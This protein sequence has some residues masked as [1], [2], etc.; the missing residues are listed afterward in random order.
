[1]RLIHAMCALLVALA[2]MGAAPAVAAA[3]AVSLKATDQ[4]FRR[5]VNVLGY[6]PYWTNTSER[7]FQW[8]HFA[9]IRKAGFDFVRVNLQA[10]SHMDDQNRLDSVWLAKLDE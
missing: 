7:R 4:P 6:D 1:M 9:E 10:F 2:S 8:R 5:G 3:P